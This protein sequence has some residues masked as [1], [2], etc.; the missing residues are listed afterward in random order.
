MYYGKQKRQG[1]VCMSANCCWQVDALILLGR[2]K[3]SWLA[4]ILLCCI[5]VFKLVRNRWGKKLALNWINIARW[6]SAWLAWNAARESILR[7]PNHIDDAFITLEPIL[8]NI[9]EF[10]WLS[11]LL[12][13]FT[14]FFIL[15]KTKFSMKIW[16]L[17]GNKILARCEVRRRNLP[18]KPKAEPLEDKF[19]LAE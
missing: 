13:F 3:K 18:F 1:V 14:S 8:K 17:G 11:E 5:P 9:F 10:S 16:K 15:F 4:G 7:S 12:Y 19:R 2:W 6:I